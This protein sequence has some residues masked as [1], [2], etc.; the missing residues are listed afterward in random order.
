M[1]KFVMSLFMVIIGT[2]VFA[3][4]KIHCLKNNKTIDYHI[5]SANSECFK[6]T[7]NVDSCSSTMFKIPSVYYQ[8]SDSIIIKIRKKY[9][10]DGNDDVHASYCFSIG[11]HDIAL[12]LHP[13]LFP[14]STSG[15]NSFVY[16][17]ELF[18]RDD[19]K[20]WEIKN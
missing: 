20:Y 12:Y 19:K 7:I 13:K 8:E 2:N 15:S 10:S 14:V 3:Q 16:S 6:I 4:E 5:D 1:K 17:I 9:L 11:R 18:Y